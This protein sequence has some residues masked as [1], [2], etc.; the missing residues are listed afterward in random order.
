MKNNDPLINASFESP[1]T[2]HLAAHALFVKAQEQE[3]S[4][5]EFKASSICCLSAAKLILTA[6]V[7]II[8]L[9]I[10][11]A[12]VPFGQTRASTG[13]SGSH[14]WYGANANGDAV[15]LVQTNRGVSGTVC[16]H[17]CLHKLKQ[18]NDDRQL[19]QQVSKTSK[20]G[21]LTSYSQ[22]P[23]HEKYTQAFIERLSL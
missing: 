7:K 22:P 20:Q 13:V 9:P 14:I 11:G 5:V 17:G 6:S 23:L 8:S 18:D 21:S 10:G 2:K 12:Q 3:Q 1:S 16:C 19:L 15:V 4:T